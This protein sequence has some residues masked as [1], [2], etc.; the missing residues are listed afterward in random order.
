M[1]QS[2]TKSWIKTRK[3]KKVINQIVMAIME[4]IRKSRIGILD[5]LT[6]TP[7][8]DLLL[9]ENY[10]FTA[11]SNLSLISLSSLPD[12]PVFQITNNSLLVTG[13]RKV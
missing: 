6:V 9:T 1:Y 5:R 4:E 2:K 3:Y 13:Q 7:S 11:S 12:N 8:S 10:W